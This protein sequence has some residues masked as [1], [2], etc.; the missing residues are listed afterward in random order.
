MS[1]TVSAGLDITALTVEEF[2]RVEQDIVQTEERD[3]FTS[4][5]GLED[6]FSKLFQHLDW[7][8]EEDGE[9]II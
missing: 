8:R 9:D 4:Y 3:T 2:H 5:Q 6:R 1:G 7:D